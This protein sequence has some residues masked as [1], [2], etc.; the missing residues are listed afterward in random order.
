M[1]AL[2]TTEAA[3]AADSSI[4]MTQSHRRVR[5]LVYRAVPSLD[6][7]NSSS[8]DTT[9]CTSVRRALYM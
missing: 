3:T 6:T 9:S 2:L 7:P 4:G 8:S 1:L 5:S